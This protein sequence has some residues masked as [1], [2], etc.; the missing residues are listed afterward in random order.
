MTPA[1]GRPG[2]PVLLALLLGA[3]AA[4][5]ERSPAQATGTT[6]GA[7]LVIPATAR[8]VGLGGA[9][10]A[11]VGDEGNIFV[12]PAG[13]AA[14]RHAALGMSYERY[15]F[16]AYLV[17]GGAAFR[18]GHFD[19][20]VGVHVLNYGQDTVFRPDPAFGGERGLA[21]PGGAMVGAYN[22]VAVGA[23]A[24]RFGMFSLGG[25]VK[26]L[27]EHLSIPDTTLYDAS[28]MGFDL[29]GALAVFDI[30]AFG[31]VVQNL[32]RDLKTTT[33]TPAPLPRTVRAGFM[34]NVKDPLGTTRLMVVGDWVSPRAAKAYWIFGVEGGVISG[35][36][37]L[38]GRAGI[39][40]G[41]APT[42]QKSL[43][44]GAGLVFH[45]LR[46]DYGYQGF[47]TMG[48]ATQRFGLQWLP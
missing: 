1:A 16:D 19:L 3:G 36:V 38:L 30:A 17:S 25:S 10:T 39:A 33:G 21:D 40:T 34:L 7:I 37:G 18:A 45:N 13:L 41:R 32:G 6:S 12:N 27:K 43:A 4:S 5:P 24:Y 2:A 22:A 8:A 20:G 23:A 46:L 48:G 9:F 44:F 15:L 31:V 14:I 47:S 26:Y 11:V 42:D 35:G 29:G 28:G